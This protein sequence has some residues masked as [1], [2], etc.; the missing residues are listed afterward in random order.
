MSKHVCATFPI[1]LGWEDLVTLD[2]YVE[3][4]KNEDD[5]TG[6]PFRAFSADIVLNDFERAKEAARKIGWEG[7]FREKPRVFFVPTETEMSYGFVWKQDN[8]GTTFIA[9][10][11]PM[12][13]LDF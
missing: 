9:S 3:R 12:P 10:P 6:Y 11:I 13:H 1:D 2:E 4:L 7:D 5:R 8:N